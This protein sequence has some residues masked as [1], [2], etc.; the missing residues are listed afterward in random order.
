VP[1]K[2]LESASFRVRQ[3]ELDVN[4]AMLEVGTASRRL[5]EAQLRLYT[6]RAEENSLSRNLYQ[7]FVGW[8]NNG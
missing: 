4:E 8:F 1:N 5:A 3:C 2:R 6:A 7:R